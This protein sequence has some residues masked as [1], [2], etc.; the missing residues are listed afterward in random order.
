MTSREFHRSQSDWASYHPAASES[1][2]GDQ[3]TFASAVSQA[4]TDTYLLSGES[5]ESVGS[6]YNDLSCCIHHH[7]RS[8]TQRPIIYTD[9]S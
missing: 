4:V 5:E 1:R 9:F 3:Y 2:I 8:L 6:F 7:R